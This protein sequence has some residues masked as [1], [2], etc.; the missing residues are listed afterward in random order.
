MTVRNMLLT[1][2]RYLLGMRK[3]LQNRHPDIWKTE[4][5]KEL[6]HKETT[7]DAYQAIDQ[8][9]LRDEELQKKIGDKEF[10]VLGYKIEQPKKTRRHSASTEQMNKIT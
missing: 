6:D 7:I 8:I 5:Q 4:Q 3:H 1:L 9:Y 2:N 10:P